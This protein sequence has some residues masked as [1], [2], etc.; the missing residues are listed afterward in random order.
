MQRVARAS[1]VC[2]DALV[3]TKGDA[4]GADALHM[5]AAS[6]TGESFPTTKV[7][8]AQPIS[9][10]GCGVCLCCRACCKWPQLSYPFLMQLS[11]PRRS[12][13]RNR[14]YGRWAMKCVGLAKRD[15]SSGVPGRRGIQS[16]WS[17]RDRM[18]FTKMLIVTDTMQI[19]AFGCTQSA[20]CV[21]CYYLNST[22]GSRNMDYWH[23]SSLFSVNNTM[24]P[25]RNAKKP[26]VGAIQVSA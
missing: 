8:N 25:S 26:S 17:R 15:S 10:A 20:D 21:N 13:Q 1:L 7:A 22:A 3:Q 18:Q 6:L 2:G 14:R 24:T 19:I 16:A 9:T 12:T 23:F 5:Q 4:V 11:A